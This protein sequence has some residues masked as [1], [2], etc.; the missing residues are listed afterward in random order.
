MATNIILFVIKTFV[1]IVGALVAEHYV[2]R[3]KFAQIYA[4]SSALPALQLPKA[5]G[6]V[7]MVNLVF[8]GFFLVYLGTKV[9]GARATFK[10]KA[11]KD[12]DKDAEARFSYP[13]MYAEG[14]SEHAKL[15]NCVQRGH[16]HA[17]ETYTQFIV[18]SAIGGLAYPVCTVFG[19]LLWM[20]ARI[21][22][23]EGCKTGEPNKRYQSWVAYGIWSSLILLM[24]ASVG[25]A[26]SVLY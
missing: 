23:A 26:V 5:Y 9:G 11:L 18:L 8:S 21:Q 2:L 10:A 15:F 7:I 3:D 12:G 16:Q 25:T 14:F 24:G 19:G 22:W 4:L 6:A 1:P 13:K 20:Y 17:L